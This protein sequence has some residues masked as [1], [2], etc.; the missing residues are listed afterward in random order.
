MTA[1]RPAFFSTWLSH[2]RNG[3]EGDGDT[4][5]ERRRNDQAKL[6]EGRAKAQSRTDPPRWASVS[7]S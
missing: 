6:V 3:A 4:E 7:V 1:I 2:L 5:E